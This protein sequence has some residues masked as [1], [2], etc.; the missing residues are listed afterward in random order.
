MSNNLKIIFAGTPDFAAASLQTLITSRHNVIAVYT[1]PDRPVGRGQKVHA[2]SVKIIALQEK[3]PVFQP[4]KLDEKEYVRLKKLDA[5]VMIVSAYGLLLPKEILNAPK[6]G[7]INI[8]A[9]LLPKW[10]GAA[11]IQRAIIAGDKQTG[12]TIMQMVEAL[13]AGPIL[14]QS[15]CDIHPT[16]TG[17]ILHDR[18]AK[19]SSTE[20]ISALDL[21]QNN[22]LI[23]ISQDN[24]HATYANKLTKKEADINWNESALEIEIKIRAY[25][26][27]P[28]A[29]SY[30]QGKRV[31][32]WEANQGETRCNKG[33]GAVIAA[34]KN[35]IEVC[36][37][38]GAISLKSLQLSGGKIIS[39]QD[40]NNTYDSAG[41]N[42]S[43]E[44]DTIKL[45]ERA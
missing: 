3:L 4:E 9:S 24:T 44:Q 22:Q 5:D 27:W 30:F 31:R 15:K 39:A 18:L 8:H 26:S 40:F 32:I 19:L 34:N 10:R 43:N 37:G 2:S 12:I 17:K 45:R 16:D 11:P 6:N 21:L 7:C 28:V 13:D 20:I 1:Q 14:F 29:Y 35:G 36:T 23:P 41:K 38:N 42:F 33:P 25:N